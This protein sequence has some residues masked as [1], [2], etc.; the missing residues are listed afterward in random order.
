[1]CAVTADEFRHF[2]EKFGA[3]S[4]SVV[5]LDRETNRSRGFGFVTFRDANVTERV[6]ALGTPGANDGKDSTATGESTTATCYLE[7]RGKLVEVKA[8][9]PKIMTGPKLRSVRRGCGSFPGGIVQPTNGTAAARFFAPAPVV[10]GPYTSYYP[11]QAHLPPAPLIPLDYHHT[12]S[13]E[14]GSQNAALAHGQSAG[15]CYPY[16]YYNYPPMICNGYYYYQSPQMYPQQLS[17][18]AQS[19]AR[20][21]SPPRTATDNN[22]NKIN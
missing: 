15:H 9:E 6:L 11:M 2:F 16:Y 18:A 20:K 21:A 7:M 3:V 14:D 13:M 1:M 19:A 5:M 4:D 17:V 22:N 12:Y 8:S 10:P